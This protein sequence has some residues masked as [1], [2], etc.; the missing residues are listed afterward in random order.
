MTYYRETFRI[1]KQ[2]FPVLVRT[3]HPAPHDRMWEKARAVDPSRKPQRL[4][5][6]HELVGSLPTPVGALDWTTN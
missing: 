2:E 1:G 6:P 4:L 3:D 5:K